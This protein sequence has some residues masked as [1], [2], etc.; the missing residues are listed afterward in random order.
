M[1]PPNG[2]GS[3]DLAVKPPSYGLRSATDLL[4][5]NDA[6]G[7]KSDDHR[8]S[9]DSDSAFSSSCREGI[10][11]T[12]RSDPWQCYLGT[13]AGQ[14]FSSS[15]LLALHKGRLHGKNIYVCSLDSCS[16][17]GRRGFGWASDLTK[18]L[19]KLHKLSYQDAR[20]I[21]NATVPIPNNK[22]S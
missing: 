14:S 1:M 10:V 22:R 9:V 15:R 20:R 21:V 16:D 2:N 19:Q 3:H 17:R 7:H 5:R 12:D 4:M 11:H 13:C 18:H 6:F 8:G